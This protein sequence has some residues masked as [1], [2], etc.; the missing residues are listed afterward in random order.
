M[1]IITVKMPRSIIKLSKKYYDN[2]LVDAMLTRIIKFIDE[3][4]ELNAARSYNG[5]KYYMYDFAICKYG[6]C[7]QITESYEKNY[8]H[9]YI[10]GGTGP[11]TCAVSF[12][13]Y[14]F[15]NEK[16]KSRQLAL[17]YAVRE[18]AQAYI[19]EKEMSGNFRIV[20][21]DINQN[22]LRKGTIFSGGYTIVCL[23]TRVAAKHI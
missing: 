10:Y 7:D 19:D 4:S 1:E 13:K 2:N 6:F 22:M 18:Q 5:R 21:L 11:A 9:I 8:C 23:P 16:R 12:I 20:E 15:G 14:G 3:K 17:L